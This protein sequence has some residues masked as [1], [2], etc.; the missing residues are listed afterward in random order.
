VR[1]KAMGVNSEGAENIAVIIPV[2]A[3]QKL[4]DAK[5]DDQRQAA[6][7]E[8]RVFLNGEPYALWLRDGPPSEGWKERRLPAARTSVAQAATATDQPTLASGSATVSSRFVN[9]SLQARIISPAELAR[10]QASNEDVV[11]RLVHGIGQDALVLPY[12]AP[13][14]AAFRQGAYLQLPSATTLGVT[15]ESSR[16]K[17][18]ALAFDEHVSHLVHTVLDYF[19]QTS[20]FAGISVSSIVRSDNGSRSLAVESSFQSAR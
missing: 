18:A 15:P 20:D 16:Y 9:A 4:V 14:F 10:I 17:L 19:R 1:H 3:A 5:T 11:D 8:A 6:A 7:L 13:S 12:A 2:T